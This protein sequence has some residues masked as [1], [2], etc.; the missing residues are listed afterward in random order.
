M[1]PSASTHS[2]GATLTQSA[3][4]FDIH[5]IERDSSTFPEQLRELSHVPPK[6]FCIGDLSILTQPMIAIVGTRDPTSY[7]ERTTRELAGAFA[8]SGIVLVSGMARGIDAIVHRTALENDG[9]T[10]AVL[11]TGVDVPYPVGHRQLHRTIAARG[12]VISENSPGLAPFKGAFPRRNRIIAAL[13]RAT[14]VVEAGHKSGA[15]NTARHAMDI[16]RPVAAVPGPID[17]PQ[18][19]GANHLIRDG[20]MVIASVDDALALMGITTV[21]PAEPIQLSGIEARVWS[22]IGLGRIGMDALAGASGL[23]ARQCMTV[24]T[25]LELRGIVECLVS[26][27]VRRR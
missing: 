24:V 21:P 27:E 14:I 2:P 26:G 6:L 22:A 7:G 11:G 3:R 25:M 5:L 20:A 10:I 12:L 8:R 23:S 4:G 15:L 19:A 16:D 17:S 13:G 18:S 1:A 9:R